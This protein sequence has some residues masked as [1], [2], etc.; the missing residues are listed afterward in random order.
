M[1]YS[2]KSI[3]DRVK[4]CNCHSQRPFLEINN[5]PECTSCVCCILTV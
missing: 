4:N 3:E 2:N 1:S 5:V